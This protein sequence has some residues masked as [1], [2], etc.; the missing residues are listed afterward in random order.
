MYDIDKYNVQASWPLIFLISIGH[1]LFKAHMA[2][3][4]YPLYL[5]YVRFQVKNTDNGL[6]NVK[7][8]FPLQNSD[9]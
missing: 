9:L 8:V 4:I 2:F 5:A 1:G 7:L 3:A 6:T